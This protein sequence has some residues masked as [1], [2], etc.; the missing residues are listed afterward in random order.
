VLSGI[1]KRFFFAAEK[2]D[3]RQKVDYEIKNIFCI[4]PIK[5]CSKKV[6]RKNSKLKPIVGCVFLEKPNK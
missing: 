1:S 3:L 6:G 2:I 4:A 5:L